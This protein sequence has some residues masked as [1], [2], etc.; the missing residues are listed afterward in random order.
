[1]FTISIQSI[2]I[3]QL[4]GKTVYEIFCIQYFI[5][6][7]LFFLSFKF[8]EITLNSRY[9]SLKHKWFP[10]KDCSWKLYIQFYL[11]FQVVSRWQ[12]AAQ[13]CY[14]GSNKVNLVFMFELYVI[15][16][17]LLCARF[18]AMILMHN[19]LEDGFS[20]DFKISL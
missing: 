15:K 2:A 17:V 14:L 16:A 3:K 7:V 8:I 19:V 10:S 20:F 13:C 5:K 11:Y 9:F 6:N 18:H 12:F 4:I 1:M